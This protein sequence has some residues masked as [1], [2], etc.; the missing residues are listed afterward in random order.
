M[1]NL[2]HSKVK[3][4][5]L[6]RIDKLTPTAKANWGKMN[7]NQNLRHI[8][9]SFEIATGKLDPT[10]VKVPPIPKWLFKLILLNA[11][12]PKEKAET[13]EETNMV[14]NNINPADFEEERKNLKRVIEDFVNS[15][16]LVPVNKIAGKFKKD[17]WGKLNYNHI[18]HHLRQFGV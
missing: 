9:M 10:P 12:P 17:D 14:A 16:S 7:V 8:S 1:K 13:F 11:K 4:E 6:S 18:D 3:E 2:F 5:I 15:D